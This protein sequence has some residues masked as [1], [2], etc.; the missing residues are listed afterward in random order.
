[1][2]PRLILTNAEMRSG[3]ILP[4]A[5]EIP[6]WMERTASP[7][8]AIEQRIVTAIAARFPGCEVRVAVEQYGAGRWCADVFVSPTPSGGR[9]YT[10]AVCDHRDDAV[11]E[12]ATGLGV[13]L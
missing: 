11:R 1:M 13:A 8:A 7:T 2:S 5:A 4:S 10:D 3:V 6:A 9:F 12:L